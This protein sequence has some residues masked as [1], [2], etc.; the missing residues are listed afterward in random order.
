MEDSLTTDQTDVLLQKLRLLYDLGR[1]RELL[2]LAQ[3]YLAD[4]SSLSTV[5]LLA[6]ES[7]VQL[8]DYAR[9][10]TI[11]HTGLANHP[12]D[13]S[14]LAM[15][16][17]L[18]NRL[19]LYREALDCADTV[20]TINP[21][22]DGVW[23][24]QSVV[25][26]NIHD[27][28][29]AEQSVLK[30]RALDPLDIDY[31]A[32]HA[33]ILWF[34]DKNDQALQMVQEGL[35]QQPDHEELLYLHALMEK[36]RSRAAN[37]LQR[38]LGSSPTSREAQQQ[39]RA[40]TSQFRRSCLIAGLITLAHAM[41]RYLLAAGWFSHLPKLVAEEGMLYLAGL[42]GLSFAKDSMRNRRLLYLYVACNLEMVWLHDNLKGENWLL[43]LAIGIAAAL[44]ISL[45]FTWA[46]FFYRAMFDWSASRMQGL[47]H[48]YRTAASSG[49]KTAW[50][51]EQLRNPHLPFT[52]GGGL[53][54]AGV[55]LLDPSGEFYA[56]AL[57][58]WFGLL[59]VLLP[60]VRGAAFST[61]F[62]VVIVCLLAYIPVIDLLRWL[63][64]LL[65]FPPLL[66][67]LAVVGGSLTTAFG[68]RVLVAD[69]D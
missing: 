33:Q 53:V 49:L 38:L 50:I 23:Y 9:A 69:T 5:F 52:I 37:I 11:L 60:L 14:L 29:A 58:C 30:A 32:H 20:L 34:M 2:D 1:Y 66:A 68:L 10:Q 15:Q 59:L 16:I 39:Y 22:H 28:K 55:S 4:Q 63:P 24:L 62:A 45:L 54:P 41:F 46:L 25:Q 31:H 35:A 6:A 64:E 26:Y 36:N 18:L 48:G 42:A 51:K 67:L 27:L 43:G 21:E 19:G 56:N 47:W 40:L 57:F 65:P 61:A 8:E 17:V 7:A 13:T 44:L 12:L 3:P